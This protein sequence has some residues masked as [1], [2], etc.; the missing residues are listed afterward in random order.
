ME[1]GGG[2][3]KF[4]ESQMQNV[5]LYSAGRRFLK[6]SLIKM[7]PKL[8]ALSPMKWISLFS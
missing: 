1:W 2:R 4:W 7:T 8:S 3:Q 5:A 6:K